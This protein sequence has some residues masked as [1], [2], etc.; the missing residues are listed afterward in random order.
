M[1]QGQNY[2]N[3]A[4]FVPM[5]HVGVLVPFLVNF[6]W[7]INRMRSGVT[8]E[9]VMGLVMAL[10]LLLLAFSVRVMVMT[11]QDRVIRLEM[12]LRLREMLPSAM[13]ADIPRL[14]IDQLVALRFASDAELPDLTREA[15]AGKFASRK[16]IKM[17]VRDWQGDYLRA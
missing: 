17:K 10:A 9:T 11:V 4:R 13:H 7:A 2:K 5:F 1:E 16:A 14:T 6:V 8:T 15:L 12:R 3:H